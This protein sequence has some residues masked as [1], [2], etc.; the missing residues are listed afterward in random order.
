[1]IRAL[2]LLILL[3]ACGTYVHIQDGDREVTLFDAKDRAEFNGGITLDPDTGKITG[4]NITSWE[5]NSSNVAIGNQ[6]VAL[7]ALGLLEGQL[8]VR[9]AE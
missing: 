7:K 6:N 4:F 2:P 5:S 1:M 3:S 9:G 8:P